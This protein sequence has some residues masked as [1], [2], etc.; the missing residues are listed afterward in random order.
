ME[1]TILVVDDDI[2]IRQMFH[3]AFTQHGYQVLMAE[4]A[5]Q[6]VEILKKENI[7]VILLDLDLPMMSGIDLCKK[8]RKEGHIGFV[9]AITGAIDV[10][11]LVQCRSAGFDDFFTKPFSLDLIIDAVDRAFTMLKRW[12]LDKYSFF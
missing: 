11:G 7:K 5:E 12:Q 3:S 8:I 6:T 2:T 9:Y 4:S 10:Y 1:K